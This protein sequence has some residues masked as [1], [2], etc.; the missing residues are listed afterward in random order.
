MMKIAIDGPAGAGKSTIAQMI[1]TKL[2]FI[3]IDT[4]AMYRAVTY[5]ALQ[6]GRDLEDPK[7]YDF[8]KDTTF[9]FIDNRL[10]LDGKDI[11]KEIRTVEVTENVSTPSKIPEVRDFLVHYQRKLCENKNVV[12]DGRDIG[13]V[14]LPDADL[15]IYLDASSYERAKRRMIERHT[16]GITHQTIEEIQEEIELRDLKDST[17]EVSPLKKADDAIVIDTSDLSIDE[18]VDRIVLLIN[19]KMKGAY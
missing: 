7:S 18:V 15:K 1:A 4:G 13:T 10:Y 16:K 12:M 2:G 11:S 5:K 3:Y 14:V 8:L 6:L 19:E 9:N 17:R